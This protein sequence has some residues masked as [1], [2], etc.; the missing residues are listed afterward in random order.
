MNR[1]LSSIIFTGTLC[2]T[3]IGSTSAYNSNIICDS[4]K[5]IVK[6]TNSSDYFDLNCSSSEVKQLERYKTLPNLNERNTNEGLI[7]SASSFFGEMRNLT[8]DEEHAYIVALDNLSEST[9]VTL[10]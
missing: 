4:T 7:S 2:S 5:M 1:F 9:G 10:F 3:F 8:E 6:N